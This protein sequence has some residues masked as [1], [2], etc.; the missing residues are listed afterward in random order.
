[1]PSPANVRNV[2][3][4]LLL[5]S[6]SGTAQAEGPQGTWNALSPVP[7]KEAPAPAASIESTV[8]ADASSREQAS[9]AAAATPSEPALAEPAPAAEPAAPELDPLSQQI[10]TALSAGG[11]D[12]SL[13][14]FYEA[15][16]FAPAW[17]EGDRFTDQADA[18]MARIRK[19]DADGLDAS[20]FRLPGAAPAAGDP[21]AQA[22]A[23]I[24]ISVAAATYARQAESGRIRPSSVDP[25]VAFDPATPK[26]QAVLDDLLAA[27]DPAAALEA[28]NPPY[29]QFRELRA[30]LAELRQA[31]QDDTAPVHIPE[32]PTLRPGDT[33]HRVML[34]RARLHVDSPDLTPVYDHDLVEAVRRFQARHGLS[35]DGAVGPRTLHAL[36]GRARPAD[37]IPQI[38]V[39]MERWRWLPREL[40]DTHIM[41]NV[42]EFEARIVRDGAVVHQT[43]VITGKK[44]H[45]TPLFSDAMEFIIVNPAWNIPYSIA[46]KEM[47]PMLQRDP[48]YLARQGIEVLYVGGRRP[49]V[50]DSTRIDWSR[51][52]LHQLR[53]RQPP[54]ERNALGHIKF[55]FP[56][57][58]AVYLHDTPSRS[59][60]GNR[61]RAF[62]HGCV[63]VQDP[64]SLADVL[65]EGSRWNA[66]SMKRL[67]GGNERRID[68]AHKVPIHI[69]YF[70][71]RMDA[72]DRLRTFGDIYG[73]DAKMKQML[74]LGTVLQASAKRS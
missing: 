74:G 62:S 56:N 32:G 68:L 48:T 14:A 43:R 34:L 66:E 50:V 67:I 73:Y 38:L 30:K 2:L 29:E 23:D 6:A 36:N 4:A 13:K 40:G 35:P 71:A 8:P 25:S 21:A 1:M 58:Y 41:V 42:P 60:F 20:A 61:V 39:N 7:A 27:N 17:I 9:P 24:E 47:L 44:D 64:F 28:Y 15:R 70:T 37:L 69:V 12:P 33:D 59:L 31:K 26:A 5:V 65:L 19:A 18:V 10:Q 53:F 46:S 55:M 16:N 54:G 45:Q 72:G 63:R 3:A 51:V 57:K 22:L 11:I 52:N 49:V